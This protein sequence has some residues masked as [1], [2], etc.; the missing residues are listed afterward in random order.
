MVIPEKMIDLAMR[1]IIDYYDKSPSG[2]YIDKQYLI[3]K[4]IC[5]PE[6]IDPLIKYLCSK[7]FIDYGPSF[8][9]GWDCI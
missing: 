8:P 4:K 1:S 5:G 3:K 2:H 9:G 6:E 7:E